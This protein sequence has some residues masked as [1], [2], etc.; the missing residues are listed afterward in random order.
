MGPTRPKGLMEAMD[1]MA[2]MNPMGLR[3][4]ELCHSGETTATV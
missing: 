1:Q 2:P 3:V 4:F